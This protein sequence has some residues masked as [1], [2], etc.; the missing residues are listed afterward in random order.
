MMNPD[1]GS[2]NSHS[3]QDQVPLEWQAVQQSTLQMDWKWLY[4]EENP[5]RKWPLPAKKRRIVS[6]LMYRVLIDSQTALCSWYCCSERKPILVIK[7]SMS[8][9]TFTE[10]GNPINKFQKLWSYQTSVA[11]FALLSAWSAKAKPPFCQHILAWDVVQI[12]LSLASSRGYN[13]GT[14]FRWFFA[15]YTLTRTYVLWLNYFVCHG[16]GQV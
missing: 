11:N 2:T 7:P 3:R 10:T 9:S 6:L 12:A 1:V 14:S 5:R 16:R 13:F 15:I 8:A 4:R